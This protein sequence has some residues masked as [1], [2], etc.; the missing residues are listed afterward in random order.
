MGPLLS[1]RGFGFKS[2][3]ARMQCDRH[4][5]NSYSFCAESTKSVEPPRCFQ[6]C[7]HHF[8]VFLF[9][10]LETRQGLPKNGVS[11]NV[12]IDATGGLTRKGQGVICLADGTRSR[13]APCANGTAGRRVNADGRSGELQSTDVDSLFAA[14][15]GNRL[16][17]ITPR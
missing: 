3:L 11:Y 7:W 13:R 15:G 14:S 16:G 8:C 5:H 1:K 9:P 12:D 4:P 2:P 6:F 17:M 10:Q